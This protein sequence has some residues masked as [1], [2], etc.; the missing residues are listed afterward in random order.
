M[1][2]DRG[3]YTHINLHDDWP[4]RPSQ[5]ARV[6]IRVFNLNDG[7][8]RCKMVITRYSMVIFPIVVVTVVVP[9]QLPAMENCEYLTNGEIWPRTRSAQASFPH[10]G[11]VVNKIVLTGHMVKKLV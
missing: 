3:T 10:V 9:I 1:T 11:Q 6:W 5:D 4:S 2:L 7:A 8:L